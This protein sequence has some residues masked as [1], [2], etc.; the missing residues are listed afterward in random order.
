MDRKVIG[1]TRNSRHV[2]YSPYRPDQRRILGGSG[3]NAMEDKM[4]NQ[5]NQVGVRDGRKVEGIKSACING[6]ESKTR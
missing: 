6:I 4:K 5:E 1:I 3:M 2:Q